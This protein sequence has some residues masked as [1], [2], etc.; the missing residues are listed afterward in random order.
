MVALP[1][2]QRV[3]VDRRRYAVAA[4]LLGIGALILLGDATVRRL[5][6]ALF[7]VPT[8]WVTGGQSATASG[9]IIWFGRGTP[10]VFG[11]DITSECS[12][13]LL[14]IPLLL[15][16]AAATAFT[17]VPLAR[18]LAALLSGLGVLVLF[19]TVRVAIIAW[20]TYRWGVDSGFRYSHI[21][22]G[23]TIALVGLIGALVV[24]LVVL[25]RRSAPSSQV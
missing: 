13:V 21:Y 5:E 7:S 1:A 9:T 8:A 19:N 10:H 24:S 16:L 17:R 4:G 3:P 11:L 25:V 6:A 15:I 22:A 2:S 18:V 12:T 20:A 23:T 14:A